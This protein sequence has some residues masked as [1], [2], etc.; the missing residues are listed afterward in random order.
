MTTRVLSAP[1]VLR[2]V[3]A[4]R[5]RRNWLLPPL[6]LQEERRSIRVA[7]S[8]QA[9]K[10]ERKLGSQCN[11]ANSDVQRPIRNVRHT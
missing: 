2:G 5:E 6:L 8:G 4:K 7:P 3:D 9:P 1:R 10:E 11:P